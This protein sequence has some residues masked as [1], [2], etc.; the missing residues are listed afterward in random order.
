M[1]KKICFAG[2]LLTL[3]LFS[4]RQDDKRLSENAVTVCIADDPDRLTPF[5]STSGYATQVV[6]QIF[7][8]LL[9]VNPQTLATEP[10][11]AK[12]PPTIATIDTGKLKGGIAYTF[13]LQDA[14]RWDDGT[15]ITAADVAFSLKDRKSTR[16]NSSHS[17]LSRMPSS[18]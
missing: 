12:A 18:A 15:P 6:R 8:T 4:C 9:S 10:C 5:I 2:L 11:L 16:L 14:A 13:E 1:F 17:T 3:S 7:Q